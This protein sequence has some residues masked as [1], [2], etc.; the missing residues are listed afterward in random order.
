M[1]R[2]AHRTHSDAVFVQLSMPLTHACLTPDVK[3]VNTVESHLFYT[4]C[5]AL[6]RQAYTGQWTCP[7]PSEN[8]L[9]SPQL[10]VPE[11]SHCM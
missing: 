1:S 6:C 8:P 11:M 5:I 9:I 4:A 2:I 10:F 3:C 7:S